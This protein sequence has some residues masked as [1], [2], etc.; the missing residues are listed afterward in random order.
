MNNGYSL[1][2]CELSGVINH[3]TEDFISII[4]TGFIDLSINIIVNMLLYT[5][6]SRNI[7]YLYRLVSLSAIVQLLPQIIVRKNMR[8]AL[9]SVVCALPVFIILVNFEEFSLFKR[10]VFI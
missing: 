3:K 9:F 7:F 10:N 4:K 1:E 5:P 6:F 2:I 8:T